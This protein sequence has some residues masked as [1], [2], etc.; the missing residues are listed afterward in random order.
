MH[1]IVVGALAQSLVNFRGDLIRAITAAGHRVTAMSGPATP[2]E[3]AAI[4][5]LG[6]RHRVFA[7]DRTGIDPRGDL[8]CVGSLRAAFR[9]LEPDVVLAYTVKPVV[10]GGI[11]LRSLR[12]RARFFG[13]ITGL[14]YAFE[15]RSP[16]R[17]V[18]AAVVA[19][20]YRAALRPAEAVIFQN[21]DNRDIFVRLGIA[22][23]ETCRIV[24]GSGVETARF[25]FTPLPPDG[26]PIGTHDRA[27]TD[28]GCRFLLIAR[29]LG[30]KGLREYAEAASIVKARYPNA[31]FDL[32][33]PADTS[34]DAVPL[35]EVEGW[36]RA[37]MV[38]Y[39]GPSSDVR[40]HIARCHVFVLPSYHEGMPRSVLEAMSMGRPILT[41]DV[42][43]CRETVVAGENGWLVPKADAQA[44]ADRMIWYIENR[45]QWQEMAEASRRL[46]VQRFD[47]H[48]VNREMIAIMGL[49]RDNLE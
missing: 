23:P 18:L 38:A 39:L 44:L 8:R 47:V 28:V 14:G 4:A 17:R 22:R 26:P 27:G 15:G 12:S 21:V 43:G 37:G 41:T 40:P 20:L 29:L 25:A 2:D 48:A 11:A 13:L 5:A 19:R 30:G 32:V 49:A 31:N 36:H 45:S 1:V 24:S 10:W 7:V 35:T 3:V 6:A 9:E 46:A 33:G 34:P 42:P 16:A